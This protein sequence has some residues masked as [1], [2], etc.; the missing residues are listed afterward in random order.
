MQ[1]LVSGKTRTAWLK[2]SF[3]YSTQTFSPFLLMAPKYL[4]MPSFW[5]TRADIICPSTKTERAEAEIAGL[6]QAAANPDKNTKK[7]NFSIVLMV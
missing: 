1:T 7:S 2:A 3:E 4:F 6:L 5:T